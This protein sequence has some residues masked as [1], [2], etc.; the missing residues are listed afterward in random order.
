[1]LS[2]IELTPIKKI[3]LAKRRKHDF[4]NCFM[5]VCWS[6]CN[7]SNVEYL[8]KIIILSDF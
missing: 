2:M 8:I 4:N 3:Y 1:M 5:N 7:N 6:I